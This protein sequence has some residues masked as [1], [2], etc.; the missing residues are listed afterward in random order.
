[1]RDVFTLITERILR[2]CGGEPICAHV[3]DIQACAVKNHPTYQALRDKVRLGRS[4]SVASLRLW[5]SVDTLARES[6]QQEREKWLI[7]LLDLLTPYFRGWS[8]ELARTWHYDVSDI[9]SA[10]VEGALA[11][12]FSL[13]GGM[14]SKKS[15]T[16]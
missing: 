11:A 15:W 7:I 10:M 14:S 2:D 4:K 3:G 6:H 16:P 5:E 12:W 8:K 13:A 9:R 1:M